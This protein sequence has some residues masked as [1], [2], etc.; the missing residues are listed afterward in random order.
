M[1]PVTARR[2]SQDNHLLRTKSDLSAKRSDTIF[3]LVQKRKS[4]FDYLVRTLNSKDGG[5]YWFN[6]VKIDRPDLE[7]YFPREQMER[8]TREYYHLGL[9]FGK[10]LELPTGPCTAKAST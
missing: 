3:K 5:F 6:C 1:E 8:Q 4:N 10:I 9:S 2:V 7:K